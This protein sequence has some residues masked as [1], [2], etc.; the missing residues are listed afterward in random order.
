MHH[1]IKQP[2]IRQIIYPEQTCPNNILG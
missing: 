1:Q 2:K